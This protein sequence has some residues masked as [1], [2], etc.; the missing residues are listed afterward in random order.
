MD[1]F[2][3]FLLSVLFGVLLSG[4]W[5]MIKDKQEDWEKRNKDE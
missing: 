4:A 1:I 3:G 5:L 2:I